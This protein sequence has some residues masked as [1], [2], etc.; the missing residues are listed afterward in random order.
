[1]ASAWVARGGEDAPPSKDDAPWGE[2]VDGLACRVRT[3][4]NYC[5]GESITVEVEL[6][7]VSERP[8]LL[9]KN[10]DYK[11]RVLAS[12]ALV[13][14]DGK[15]LQSQQS[16]SYGN[17]V[18][19][20]KNFIELKAGES[21][22]FEFT[23]LAEAFSLPE[24]AGRCQ[25]RYTYNG[26]KPRKV[27]AS[28]TI[29]NGQR[30]ET[31]AEPTQEQVE[32]AWAGKVE[33]NAAAF[34]WSAPRAE[35]LTVH[36]WGVF[37]VYN[38]LKY[39]NAGRLAEWGDL[40]DYFYRQFPVR[41]MRWV[42]GAW[43]KP[44]VY[45]YTQRPSLRVRARVDFPEGCPVVW[46]PAAQWPVDEDVPRKVIQRDGLG[47]F[48]DTLV[49][50]VQL[51]DRVE[52]FDGEFG[53]PKPKA[54][55]QPKELPEACWL[56]EARKVEKA[57]WIHAE[58]SNM[59]GRA[60]WMSVQ[61]EKEKFLY[62]DGLAPAPDYLRCAKSEG[63]SLTLRNK[64][65]FALP[66]VL[67]IDNRGEGGAPKR[68]ALLETPLAA[69]GEASVETLPCAGA[70][71]LADWEARLKRLLVEAGLFEAEASSL[72]SIWRKGFFEREGVTALFLLP[73]EE[74]DRMLPMR[75]SPQPAAWARVGLVVQARIEQDPELDK[76]I[77]ALIGK[78]DADDF[79][80]REAAKRELAELGH[81]TFRYL[82]E[83]S[84][85]E[86][87]PEVAARCKE[88]LEAFDASAYLEK[89]KAALR[90]GKLKAKRLEPFHDVKKEP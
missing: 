88:L 13:T 1:M 39:A 70:E 86:D 36:E 81:V 34:E 29:R 82:H 27:V 56:N 90:A 18:N 55:I 62:Y 37:T 61:H 48:F 50:D 10:F 17:A 24:R 30:E 84:K 77:E 14:P 45:F 2:A 89:A 67:A 40:P 4:P 25:V 38:D 49:W 12:L 33:S 52:R 31:F 59:E 44:I 58:G 19:S 54:A 80:S 51:G 72:V 3:R 85:K 41:R 21:T 74:Y 87:R 9:R 32:R 16:R 35:D 15:E 79:D 5:F 63:A 57:A 20:P 69:Q 66:W 75:V 26:S 68:L 8:I 28:V 65:G 23:N 60:P 71:A 73:R 42:P 7:N 46:W 43:D 76:R 22:R 53:G 11:D 47:E 6:K 78:L 64:A 83:A